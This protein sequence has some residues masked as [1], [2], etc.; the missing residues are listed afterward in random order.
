MKFPVTLSMGEQIEVPI[1]STFPIFC[2]STDIVCLVEMRVYSEFIDTHTHCGTALGYGHWD[3]SSDPDS[4]NKLTLVV[5]DDD[6]QKGDDFHTTVKF[7]PIT[8][9]TWD[10]YVLEDDHNAIYPIYEGYR[11]DQ[12]EV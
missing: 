2:K 9:H 12:F 4:T 8:Y 7:T 1:R 10:R 5:T 6:A 3:G 11:V